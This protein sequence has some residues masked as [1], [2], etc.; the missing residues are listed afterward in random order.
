MYGNLTM[1]WLHRSR[2]TS[3]CRWGQ[4]RQLHSSDGECAVQLHKPCGGCGPSVE[5][6]SE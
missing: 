2:A 4:S 6:G 3:R 5:P 1:I